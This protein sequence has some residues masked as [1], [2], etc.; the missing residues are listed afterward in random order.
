MNIPARL[1]SFKTKALIAL[2]LLQL[3]GLVTLGALEYS[4]S[5]RQLEELALEKL[6]LEMERVSVDLHEY[7]RNEIRVVRMLAGLPHLPSLVRA[8]AESGAYPESRN[9]YAMYSRQLEEILRSTAHTYPQCVELAFL[10]GEGRP[11]VRVAKG[12]TPF[13]DEAPGPGYALSRT[14]RRGGRRRTPSRTRAAGPR[15]CSF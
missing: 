8:R 6:S 3:A 2:G 4:Q 12:E 11:I 9:V 7:I 5:R 1:F 14:G 13:H 15:S 10:D